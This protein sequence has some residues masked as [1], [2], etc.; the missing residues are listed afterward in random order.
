[1]DGQRVV[2]KSKVGLELIIPLG[3]FYVI[4]I[5]LLWP[6]K[7][8]W[9]WMSILFPA[10]ALTFHPL[11]TTSYTIEGLMLTVRSGFLY[12]RQIDISSIKRVAG[13]RD[14]WSAPAASLDRLEILFGRYG[15]VLISPER[16]E[17]FIAHIRQINPAVEV[18]QRRK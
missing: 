7:P 12:K 16:K 4:L 17:E 18:R 14:P 1:M 8:R 3:I 11:V 2:Y 5:A 6:E 15:S 10:I 13:T 9:V